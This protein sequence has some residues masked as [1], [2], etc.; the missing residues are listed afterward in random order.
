[1]R[2]IDRARGLCAVHGGLGVDCMGRAQYRSRVLSRLRVRFARA[3]ASRV[4]A[5]RDDGD[6]GDGGGAR[7]GVRGARGAAG[8]GGGGARARWRANDGER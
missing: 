5:V 2:A 1:M 4:A 3:R 7:W 8:E 6:D